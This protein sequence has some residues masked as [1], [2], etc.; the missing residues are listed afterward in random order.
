MGKDS[1]NPHDK[2]VLAEGIHTWSILINFGEAKTEFLV[3]FAI[4]FMVY[5]PVL[6]KGNPPPPLPSPLSATQR[7]LASFSLAINSKERTCYRHQNR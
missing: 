1:R 4:L 7:N 3:V 5:L 2:I 6:L